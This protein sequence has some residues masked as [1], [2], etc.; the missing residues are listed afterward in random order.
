MDLNKKLSEGAMPYLVILL[1][2]MAATLPH[3]TII[4]FRVNFS[5]SLAEL[6]RREV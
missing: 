3:F 1:A 5:P 6:A 2:V 4:A